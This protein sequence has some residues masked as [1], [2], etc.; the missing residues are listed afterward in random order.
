M[1]VKNN[2]FVIKNI[3]FNFFPFRVINQNKILK[4][5]QK[6]LF[7]IILAPVLLFSQNFET[8]RTK[9]III[10]KMEFRIDS[11]SIIS[12]TLS[13]KHKDDN[14]FIPENKYIL[15]EIE[16]RIQIKDTLLIGDTLLFN[17]SV[18]PVLLSRT[19]YNRKLN[20]IEPTIKNTYLNR[21]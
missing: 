20:F 10:K 5:S 6:I 11:F 12:N 18:F 1:V 7:V 4:L 19:F 9:S 17:Y 15:N 2:N 16:S 21:Q 14:Q 8:K 3:I 13:I